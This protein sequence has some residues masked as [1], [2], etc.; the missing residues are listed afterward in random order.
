[1]AGN[2][3]ICLGDVGLQWDALRAQYCPQK[4]APCQDDKVKMAKGIPIAKPRPEQD[5]SADLSMAVVFSCTLPSSS[6]S[7]DK[8]T[9]SSPE[10]RASDAAELFACN[11][12][13]SSCESDVES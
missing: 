4:Q 6:A 3:A 11:R 10:K 13:G 7:L 8:P 1:M 2:D 9:I 5:I 12:H